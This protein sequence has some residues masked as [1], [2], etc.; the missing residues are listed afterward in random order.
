M[1]YTFSKEGAQ[2]PIYAMCYKVQGRDF[3]IYIQIFERELHIDNFKIEGIYLSLN[4]FCKK[5]DL[6][7][8]K[9]EKEIFLEWLEYVQNVAEFLVAGKYYSFSKENAKMSII[10]MEQQD[11]DCEIT[12]LDWNRDIDENSFLIVNIP[13]LVSNFTEQKGF[14]A[15]EEN[16][17]FFLTKSS[18]LFKHINH[19]VLGVL[20]P[21]SQQ[22]N[23]HSLTP[24]ARNA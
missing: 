1:F 12:L 7:S 13:N 4:G 24:N 23:N 21:I 16:Q 18:S 15:H 22:P 10:A 5:N 17:E 19:Q 2:L 11:M 8:I 20:V 6:R 9:I 3:M 14:V